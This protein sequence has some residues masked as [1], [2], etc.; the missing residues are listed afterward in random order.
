[1]SKPDNCPQELFDSMT[2]CWEAKPEARPNFVEVGRRN[3]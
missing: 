1:M 3:K 2:K